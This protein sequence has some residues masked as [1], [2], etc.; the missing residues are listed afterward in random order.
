MTLS[1]MGN[2]A[3]CAPQTISRCS[4][5]GKSRTS[6]KRPPVYLREQDGHTTLELGRIVELWGIVGCRRR[7]QGRSLVRDERTDR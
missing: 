6:L 7:C 5:A 1:P 2:D 3:S 4:A